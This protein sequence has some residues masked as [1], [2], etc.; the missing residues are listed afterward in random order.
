MDFAKAFNKVPRLRLLNKLKAHSIDGFVLNWIESWLTG[1]SQR[2]VLNGEG[3]EWKPV[4][5][6][7]PQ[8]SV[9]G[10]VCFVIFINDLDDVCQTISMI[11]KFADDTKLCNKII[12]DDDRKILQQCLDDLLDWANKWGMSFNISKCKVMHIG[13]KNPNFTYEMNGHLLETV[14]EEKDVGVYISSSLKPSL[15]C[16]KS[17]EKANRALYCLKKAFHYR[18]KKVF[19]D[20]YKTYVRPHLEYC[21]PAWNPW[22]KAD[23]DMIEGVH[24][25]VLR[26]V[27]G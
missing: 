24:K 21:S 11:K 27:S 22:S 12:N 19:I 13:N 6:G 8:G 7:V 15:H 18:D 10:P 4:E 17:V 16:K 3:S 2:V 20:L 26:M 25:R 23:T 14:T 5:S 1:R 9:L